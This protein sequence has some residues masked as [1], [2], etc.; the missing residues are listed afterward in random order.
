MTENVN[1]APP[2]AGIRVVDL[3]HFQ[4]GP[5]AAMMLADMGAEIVKIE[6]PGKGDNYRRIGNTYVGGENTYFLSVNR[7]KQSVTVNLRTD[8]GRQIVRDLAK[9]ADV[10]M[11]N[12]RPGVVRDLGLDYERIRELNPRIVYCSVSAFG[13]SG[14]LSDKPG[15]DPIMQGIGG[16][17]SIT[18]FQ[19]RPPAM[20]GAPVADTTGAILAA[21]GVTLALLARMRDGE[22]QKIEV[23]LLDGVLTLLTPREGLYFGAGIVPQ[24]WGS[25]HAQ[26]V[27]HQAFPTADGYIN[28]DVLHDE[29]WHSLCRA[30]EQEDLALDERYSSKA[31]RV[32]RRDELVAK[33]EA[34]FRTR[35]SAEW[36]ERLAAADVISGPIHTLDQ[37]LEHPQVQHNEMVVSLPHPTVGEVRMLGV[38]VKLARTPAQVRTAPPLLGQHTDDVLARELGLT[39]EQIEGLRSRGII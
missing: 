26:H 35:T 32:E 16:I 9:T 15:I 24:R 12:F 2:L 39:T 20:V 7:N 18:G 11:E 5:M 28:V 8:E 23:S 19:D 21:Y 22:G 30:L 25:A 38:P 3:T 10:F 31:A 6:P 1:Q 33:L 13:Q 17:M 37:I 27:P 34:V 29:D 36:L 14:P 4:A